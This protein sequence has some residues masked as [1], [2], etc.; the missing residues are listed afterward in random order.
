MGTRV[1][2]IHAAPSLTTSSHDR[3]PLESPDAVS[4][5]LALPIYRG[6]IDFG[7]ANV[8]LGTFQIA[9]TPYGLGAVNMIKK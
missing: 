4:S 7:L 3:S 2:W 8:L 6:K 9:I 1:P 5:S